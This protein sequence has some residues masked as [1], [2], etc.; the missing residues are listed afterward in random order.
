MDLNMKPKP[1]R[2]SSIPLAVCNIVTCDGL[3][4]AFTDEEADAKIQFIA[5]YSVY[6]K[7][8]GSINQIG[9]ENE[10]SWKMYH[11]TPHSN[12]WNKGR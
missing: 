11:V 7:S 6:R 8:V 10:H 12:S 1:Q 4:L 2:C 5:L 3:V 9:T